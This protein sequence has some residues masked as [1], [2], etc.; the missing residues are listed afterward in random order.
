MP[1]CSTPGRARPRPKGEFNDFGPPPEDQAPIREALSVGPLR[2]ERNGQLIIERVADGQPIG[3][4]GWHEVQYGPRPKSRAWNI[5][6]SLLPEAR[7]QGFRESPRDCWPTT[8]ATRCTTCRQP[9]GQERS[10]PARPSHG[11]HE[12]R[13]LA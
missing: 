8:S 13:D 3:T 1:T 12:S 2:N 10:H 6:I 11:Q 7:G 9:Q 5:G 4:G